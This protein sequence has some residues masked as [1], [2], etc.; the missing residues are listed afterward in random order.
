MPQKAEWKH[1]RKRACSNCGEL[2]KPFR[3][4]QRFCSAP[5][6]S[7]FHKHG[8]ALIQIKGIAEKEIS[9]RVDD[10]ELRVRSIVLEEL[11]KLELVS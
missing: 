9:R 8:G 4:E 5:C 6:R 10:L 7:Q 2:Y 3:P 1:L 11:K